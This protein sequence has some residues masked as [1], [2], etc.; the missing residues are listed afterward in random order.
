[1]SK[2]EI[3]FKVPKEKKVKEKPFGEGTM[4]TAAFFQSIRSA[5]RQKS[6]FYP[7]IS[8]CRND[9]K[10]PYKGDN[11]RRKYS[12]ICGQ[13]GDEVAGDECAVHHKIPCGQ[14]NSFDDIG[15]FCRKLF[16]SKS[17]LILLCDS[18]HE[19]LHEIEKQKL[20]EEKENNEEK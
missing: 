19:R 7:A 14:L 15:E 18:C 11:K 17:D 6:R 2:K 12:Y 20:K 8:A 9:S 3:K 10:I 5:L 16:C 13:C 4:T 1:M